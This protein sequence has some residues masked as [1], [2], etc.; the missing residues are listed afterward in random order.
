[1][2]PDMVNKDFQKLHRPDIQTVV[3][4]RRRSSSELRSVYT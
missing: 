4:R 2:L 1:V 3:G